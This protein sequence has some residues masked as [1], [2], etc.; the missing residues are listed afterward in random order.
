[1]QYEKMKKIDQI[2]RENTKR[3]IINK[4]KL[5]RNWEEKPKREKIQESLKNSQRKTL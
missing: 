1:M 2:L 4:K 3:K 5:L